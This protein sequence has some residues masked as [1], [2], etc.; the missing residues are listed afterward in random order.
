[1]M[2]CGMNSVGKMYGGSWVFQGLSAEV[3]SG[4]RIGLVGVNG[5]GKTTLLKSIAGVEQVD[6]GTIS[7]QKGARI[8]YLA[9]VPERGEELTVYEVLQRPFRS[10]LQIEEGIQEV[11]AEMGR[12]G[13]GDPDQLE[14]L[15]GKYERLQHRFEED[16]GYQIEAQVA[17]VANGLGLTPLLEQTYHRLSGGEKTKV[18]LATVLLS[19]P[20]L[21]L[22]DEPTNHLDLHAIEWLEGYIAQFTGAV[23][24]VSHDRYFLDR[25]VTQIW[26]ME[27]GELITY[28]GNYSTF[29]KAKEEF[30][31]NQFAAY[32]EQE[33]KIKKMKETIK[34]LKEWANRANP[35]NAG[36]HR[37]AKSMEKAL[38]RMVK[39]NRPVRDRKK[40]GLAFGKEERSGKEVFILDEVGKQFGERTLFYDVNLRV[41][42]Q[43]RIALVGENGAGKSTLL[44]MI[45]GEVGPDVG[46][47]RVG[48][49]VKMGYLSQLGLEGYDHETVL[50]AFRDQ[51]PVDEGK[52]RQ[53]LAQFLFHGYAVF[54]RVKELS[55]GE[56]MRLRLAQLMHQ[57]VNTLVLDEPTNHL[58]IDSR[59]VLEEALTEFPGTIFAISHDRYFINKLFAKVYWLEEGTCTRF[60]GNYD[61]A[62]QKRAE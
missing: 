8:G 9:Q 62:K 40:M 2:I 22:L 15:M 45:L 59:E 58:D 19:R 12:L 14:R 41:Q 21:L 32:V 39:L 28:R 13:D 54:R 35:P 38:E 47:V 37:R 57:E 4:E 36:M 25:T 16:G 53:L 55:G 43:E 1:M 24:I 42:F 60:E 17:Q 61:D 20:Q 5:C 31:Y 51:V 44:K 48:S 30:L 3:K 34:R 10:L 18:G 6:E 49:R 11:T 50:S 46:E 7:I 29:V 52:A 27:D 56:R 33:K 26:D 23:V